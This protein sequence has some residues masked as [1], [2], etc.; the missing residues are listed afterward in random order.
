MIK[1]FPQRL[2]VGQTDECTTIVVEK[3]SFDCKTGSISPDCAYYWFTPA[4]GSQQS[5]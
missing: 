1:S 5:P 2:T 3:F 4:Y